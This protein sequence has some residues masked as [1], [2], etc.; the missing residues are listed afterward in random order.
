MYFDHIAARFTASAASFS[1]E[2]IKSMIFAS[3]LSARSPDVSMLWHPEYRQKHGLKVMCSLLLLLCVSCL[4]GILKLFANPKPFGYAVYGEIRD[5][6]FVVTATCG[7][8][9]DGSYKTPYV[10]TGDDDGL[11]V[12]GPV[13]KCGSHAVRTE[14]LSFVAKFT[15]LFI[16]IKVG[17]RACAVCRAGLL[18]RTLLILQWFV[19]VVGLNWL[20]YYYLDLSL[21][22]VVEEYKVQKIG[23]A[24]EMHSYA[25]V[26][27]RVA[28]KYKAKGYTIQHAAISEGK[29]W[30][31]VYPEE[32]ESGLILPDVMFVFNKEVEV[33]LRPWYEATRFVPGCSDRYSAWKNISSR[34]VAGGVYC[35]FAGA[36]AG[37]DNLTLIVA[38]KSL[39]GS[40]QL[41][42]PVKVRLHPAAQM[43]RGD[44]SWLIKA[45]QQGLIVKSEGTSLKEDLENAAIVVGMSTTVLEEA[46]LLGCPVI[47][48]INTEYLE[49]INIKGVKGALRKKHN[50]MVASDLL[51]MVGISVDHEIMRNRL[52]LHHPVVS[53]ERLFADEPIANPLNEMKA[54]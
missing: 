36:L 30:Y 49:F 22:K 41:S 23:C 46:L 34:E 40:G 8:V 13:D 5:A 11:F 42:M 12:F 45:A 26:V 19:W 27:W 33:M 44:K 2:Q 4:K 54:Y 43:S 35:L 47:Q 31:F 25:R 53:Y 20:Y 16:L 24:H 32:K 48:L 51:S 1:S 52:G 10:K 38:L 6:L 7:S 28:R 37:F 21:S 9:T 14:P 15:V 3:P 29:R 50:E 39:L 18:D 17:V